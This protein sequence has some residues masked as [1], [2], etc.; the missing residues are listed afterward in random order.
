MSGFDERLKVVL[1][2]YSKFLSGIELS[3]P[4]HNPYLDPK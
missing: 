2:G 1:D 4:Q 3:D